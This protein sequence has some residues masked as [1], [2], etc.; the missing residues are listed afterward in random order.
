MDFKRRPVGSRLRICLVA[1]VVLGNTLPAHALE[2]RSCWVAEVPDPFTGE[3]DQITRCRIVGGETVDYA[4]DSD[5]P[6]VLYPNMGTDLTGQCWYLTSATTQY[7]ILNQFGDGSAE[8]GFDTDPSNPGGIIAIGPVVPRCSSE[9]TPVSDPSADAWDYVMSYIHSP[10]M[11]DL[12]PSIGDGITGLGTHVGVAVPDDHTATLS[13]GLST[14][15]VEIEVSAVVVRWGD[16]EAST[17]LPDETP[18]SGY[19]DGPAVHVYE[20]KD[21][22]GVDLVVEYDWTARWRV[23]GGSWTPLPVPNTSTTVVYPIAEI[24]SKLGA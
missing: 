23:A 9:P 12:N 16:G 4:S 18:L 5:V 3:M 7:V 17:Y 22:D 24:V 15:E 21:P 13:S 14:L 10:P 8:I 19:P 11:P 20:S 2:F 1:V 6:D